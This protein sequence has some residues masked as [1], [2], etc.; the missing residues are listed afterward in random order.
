MS[1]ARELFLAHAHASGD[2]ERFATV[3]EARRSLTTAKLEALDQVE[4]LDEAGLRL[5]MPGLYQQI[6]KTTIQVAARVG[7][8]VGLALEALDELQSEVAIGSFSRPVRD[9][10]TETGI[11]MK[12]RHASRIAK[13]VAEIEAQRLAWRH[14]HEF[15]SWL[16]FRRDDERYPAADRRARLEAFK[17]VDRLLRGREAVSMVLGRP[18]AIALEAHDRFMLANRWRLDPLI[19]E[20][21]VESYV[22]PLL[23]FQTGEVVQLE[24]ARYHYD[25]LVA[26]GADAETRR[27]RHAELVELFVDQ[28]AR[29]LDHVPEGLGTGVV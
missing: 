23:S 1:T 29:A 28:L 27:Q 6:V 16:G 12:K 9:Q 15:M 19:P 3:N 8:A 26:A 2:D 14:N 18:L 21:A 25:A 5:V 17:I 10:M 22:W 11:A 24:L 13:L 4:G 7:V 20:H